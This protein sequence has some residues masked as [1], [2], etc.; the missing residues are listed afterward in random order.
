MARFPWPFRRNT[1]R[2][3]S[4]PAPEVAPPAETQTVVAEPDAY[5]PAPV[6]PPAVDA[7]FAAGFRARADRTTGTGLLGAWGG[8]GNTARFVVEASRLP[9]TLATQRRV[10][11]VG[12]SPGMMDNPAEFARELP[13]LASLADPFGASAESEAVFAESLPVVS[14]TD[15][16]R[17]GRRP[18]A[19]VRQGIRSAPLATAERATPPSTGA[20]RSAPV[21]ARRV[22]PERTVSSSATLAPPQ[23]RASDA[24]RGVEFSQP[25]T[26][27]SE[28]IAAPPD[29]VLERADAGGPIL[30]LAT[31]GSGEP[32]TQQA[33]ADALVQSR[34]DASMAMPLIAARKVAPASAVT[35]PAARTANAPTVR[36]RVVESG[37]NTPSATGS[38]D[39]APAS[40]EPSSAAAPA[41]L[42]PPPKGE[43]PVAQRIAP[44]GETV[45]AI[46]P[47]TTEP[48]PPAQELELPVARLI[49]EPEDGAPIAADGPSDTPPAGLPATSLPPAVPRT[50]PPR[51]FTVGEPIESTRAFAASTE[52]SAQAT[53]NAG[54]GITRRSDA[55]PTG[56]AQREMSGDSSSP[57]AASR[58]PGLPLTNVSESGVPLVMG[59]AIDAS[60]AALATELAP[61]EPDAEPISSPADTGETPADSVGGTPVFAPGSDG[62]PLPLAAPPASETAA[63]AGR[64]VAAATSSAVARSIDQSPASAGRGH[65]TQSVRAEQ[66]SEGPGAIGPATTNA[67]ALFAD[68]AP[69]PIREAEASSF[70]V[71]DQAA[72]VRQ[73]ANGARTSSPDT[74]APA[75]GAAAMP[76]VARTVDR[77]NTRPAPALPLAASS[78]GNAGFNW[79]PG[80]AGDPFGTTTASPGGERHPGAFGSISAS[81][82]TVARRVDTTAAGYVSRAEE[83]GGETSGASAQTTTET[84]E[85]G[86]AK[87]ADIES[88]TEKVWQRIRS[89]LLLERERRRGL[90]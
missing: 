51:R 73:L 12:A 70:P 80:A 83:D 29:L 88:L 43:A 56:T 47:Q 33:T 16:L 62:Q 8:L 86:P 31:P 66:G 18:E 17:E 85:D 39:A 41:D 53:S 13:S 63:P 59:R 36:A 23:G 90:P 79:T 26:A 10:D 50:G 28:S 46:G 82:V 5:I 64:D 1:D 44:P 52:S 37:P 75:G 15:T 69:E 7:G 14:G 67:A 42:T 34:V 24:A 72:F 74:A 54:P 65:L 87:E 55:Q 22:A 4:A 71:P 81:P 6:V 30:D 3:D 25:E 27:G 78:A 35:S 2:V 38:S 61:A 48:S 9:A 40:S 89:R 57:G 68:W 76:T 11:R 21:V 77:P 60:A 84:E 58:G 19:P 49:A 32:V 20:P 45:P